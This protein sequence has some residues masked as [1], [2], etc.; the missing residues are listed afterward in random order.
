MMLT[1]FMDALLVEVFNPSAV[2][3]DQATQVAAAK[4]QGA[5]VISVDPRRA[6]FAVSADSWLRVRPGTD[7]PLALGLLRLMFEYGGVDREFL[8]RWTNAALLVRDDTRDFLRGADLG[9]PEKECYLAWHS[10]RGAVPY[11]PATRRF[12]ADVAALELERSVMVPGSDGPIPCR[13]ALAHLRASFAPW[14]PERVG[15][16]TGIEAD[17]IREAA[18]M[19]SDSGSVAYYCWSGVGQHRDATQIDR[20][21]ALLTVLKGRPRCA[22]RQ[23][24]LYQSSEPIHEWIRSSCA[25]YACF[26]TWARRAPTWPALYWMGTRR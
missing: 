25:G 6:G 7:G 19:L 22:R 20:A 3:L 11:D 15:A 2:W 4:A 16:V 12:A 26:R 10:A 23:C 9:L 8:R 17:K 14:T 18:H 1:S 13:P 5:R 24:R 21:I